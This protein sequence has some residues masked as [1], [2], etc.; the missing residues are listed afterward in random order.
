LIT[1]TRNLII[2]TNPTHKAMDEF[3]SDDITFD[4]TTFKDM[5]SIY[6]IMNPININRDEEKVQCFFSGLESE[7]LL[8]EIDLTNGTTQMFPTNTLETS[9]NFLEPKYGNISFIFEGYEVEID[10]N[11]FN[12]EETIYGLPN[13][14][15]KTVKYGMGFEKKYNIIIN[16]ILK[17][18]PE[19]DTVIF[20][21]IKYTNIDG[22]SLVIND[23]DLDEVRRG[24]DRNHDLYLKES[25]EAKESFIYNELL[26]GVNPEKYPELKRKAQRD[27]IYKILK[28]TDFNKTKYSK[29]DKQSLSELKDSTDL[30]YL[31]ILTT[32]FEKKLSENHKEG[33]YQVFFEENPLLLTLFAG[34]PYVQ[35]NNQAY[36]GGKSFDNLNGQYPDFLY[37]HR[38]TNNTFIVEIKTPQTLLLEKK[39]YRKT[40]VYATSS[41]LTGAISQVLTQKYQLETDIATLIKN[42]D[43]REVEA[44][45]VQGLIIVGKISSLEDKAMKRSFELNRNNLKNLRIMT[46]DECLEQLKSFIDLLDKNINSDN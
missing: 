36:V 42:A 12:N 46:Y 5:P 29:E 32:E 10:K 4:T 17:Y 26:H 8:V 18:F 25:T 2:G 38:I 3:T 6:D 45:N 23:I 43:D 22:N 41:E 20:S 14:F 35:F 21:T 24:I 44:Y 40:G 28:N 13:I 31:T 9:R 1:T 19:C 11:D 27:V 7:R 33:V 16:S 30:S 39:M 15:T 34:S 37:K